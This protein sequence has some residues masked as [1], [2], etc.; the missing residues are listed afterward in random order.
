MLEQDQL[1]RQYNDRSDGVLTNQL[2]PIF[3]WIAK[4]PGI[5]STLAA[6]LVAQYVYY[7]K[8]QHQYSQLANLRSMELGD[9]SPAITRVIDRENQMIEQANTALIDAR[10]GYHARTRGYLMR[11]MLAPDL[12]D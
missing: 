1:I 7:D 9:T 3:R 6:E 10:R 4:T 12:T 11:W 2:D 8:E 5:T